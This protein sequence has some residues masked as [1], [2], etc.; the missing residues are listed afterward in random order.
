M[1]LTIKSKT[2]TLETMHISNLKLKPIFFEVKVLRP[3]N[4]LISR[5]YMTHNVT[6]VTK[7]L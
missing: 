2:K 1:L 7:K 6:T 4:R 3:K 5:I